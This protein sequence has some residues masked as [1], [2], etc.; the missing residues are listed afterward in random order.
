LGIALRPQLLN[1]VR[2]SLT[3]L[4]LVA[5]VALVALVGGSAY[6]LLRYYFESSTDLA[7]HHELADQLRMLNVAVPRDVAEADANYQS[8]HDP[9]PHL[10]PLGERHTA[11]GDRGLTA[12][13]ALPLDQTGAVIDRAGASAAP[14]APDS[15]A[16]AAARQTGIDTRTATLGGVPIRLLTYRIDQSGG[17][18]FLQLG[19]S[20][21]DQQRIL[22]QVLTGLLAL[23]SLCALG[24]AAVSWWLAGRSL[25][26][27]VQAWERQQTFVANAG[28][29]LRAPLTLIRA[30]ADVALRELPPDGEQR[31]L[32]DD[33]LR[34]CDHMARL[35]DDLLLL[36]RLDAGRL[37]M[38]AQPI[39]LADF[40]SDLSR[41]V[42]R[43]ADD[44]GIR[45][46]VDEAEGRAVADPERL[47]QVLLIVI[48]NA[49]RHT[50]TGGEVRLAAR[51]PN[52][53]AE[54]IVSDTGEGIAPEHL[55][56]VF[57]RF[58]VVDGSHATGGS[59]LGLSI[60]RG[61]IQAQHGNIE[62]TSQVG[63][64]TRV[65]ITLPGVT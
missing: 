7:L 55:A 44:R 62:L 41:K 51:Q 63:H 32:W 39:P 60:A 20:I 24:L 30:T 14:F 48:D 47:R 21:T 43:V 33:V 27:A 18:A 3:L 1:R 65:E 64:G 8:E 31:D 35:V 58:Y 17:P 52:G 42:Q 6:G 25:R 22:A 9:V 37:T 50:P 59:G 54:L 57:E 13:Y 11:S 2:I 45:L 15:T 34:D 16:V 46:V 29:E 38:T 56:K 5:G 61:L 26:P 4:Y 53:K 36:S 23:G 10:E 28:H 49:L 40:M 12:I 19:Q